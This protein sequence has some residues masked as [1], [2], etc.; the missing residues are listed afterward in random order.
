MVANWIQ[1]NVRVRV[2]VNILSVSR[3]L[4]FRKLVVTST[5]MNQDFSRTN[6]VANVATNLRIMS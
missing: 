5:P 1:V 3:Q 4:L 6:A 2:W